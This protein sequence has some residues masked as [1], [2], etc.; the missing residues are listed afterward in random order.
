MAGG[1]S[2]LAEHL[3]IQNYGSLP[4]WVGAVADAKVR[5]ERGELPLAAHGTPTT[6]GTFA[7]A[8]AEFASG[9][10]DAYQF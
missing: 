8:A 3:S 7:D 6:F 4:D 10:I 9:E 1:D 5:Q 2:Q